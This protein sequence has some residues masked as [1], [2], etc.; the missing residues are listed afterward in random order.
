M[1]ARMSVV[2]AFLHQRGSR[3]NLATLMKLVGLLAH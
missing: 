1:K 3:K 2:S